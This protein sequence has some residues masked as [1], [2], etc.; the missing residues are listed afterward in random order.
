MEF[1]IKCWVLTWDVTFNN[2]SYGS[3][4]TTFLGGQCPGCVPGIKLVT[5][6]VE[7]QKGSRAVVIW[8]P[9][10]HSSY[11]NNIMDYLRHIPVWR[12]SRICIPSK[13]SPVLFLVNIRP[14]FHS[15][16]ALKEIGLSH[17]LIF[18]ECFYKCFILR[19]R[20]LFY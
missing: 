1:I 14:S 19:L 11:R 13:L 10:W 8:L 2:V 5:V 9:H 3:N 15:W 17:R 7:C 12:G 16:G 18:I 20:R 4:L 6:I